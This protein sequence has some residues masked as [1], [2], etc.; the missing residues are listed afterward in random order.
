VVHVPDQVKLN[1]PVQITVEVWPTSPSGCSLYSA[2]QRLALVDEN[3]VLHPR[4]VGTF[5]L[6]MS[7][8]G[9]NPQVLWTKSVR[10]VV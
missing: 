4:K 7:Q 1:V 10:I 3:L 5:D 8:R 9:E 2:D 6:V